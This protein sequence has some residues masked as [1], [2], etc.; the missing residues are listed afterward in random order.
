MKE[1]KCKNCGAPLTPDGRCEYCGARYKIEESC[2][3]IYVVERLP[4]ATQTLGARV[5]ID[6]DRREVYPPDALARIATERISRSLAEALKEYMKIDIRE[7]P[8][9]RATII[10]GTVR[11]IPPD[12]RF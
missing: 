5:V 3:Q 1:L 2:G 6:K 12:Y 9:L 8:Y 11:V 7:D 4:P 10:E